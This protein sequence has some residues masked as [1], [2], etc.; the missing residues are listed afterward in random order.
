[1]SISFACPTCG[2]RFDAPDHLEGK[3]ARC[4]TC[5]QV[6]TIARETVPI[7]QPAVETADPLS[8]IGTAAMD[9]MPLGTPLP[10]E[11]R[12][13]AR[14]G[15]HPGIVMAIAAGG[16]TVVGL[17]VLLIVFVFSGGDERAERDIPD[18]RGARR[19]QSVS[20]GSRTR[21]PRLGEETLAA[22]TSG[23]LT[24]LTLQAQRPR[25]DVQAVD[26]GEKPI[27][28]VSFARDLPRAVVV[29]VDDN[30]LPKTHHAT[31]YN[32]ETGQAI[33]RVQLPEYTKIIGL[34]PDATAMA[35]ASDHGKRQP[36]KLALWK[37]HDGSAK[38][39]LKII[40][41][42]N[43]SVEWVHFLPP[44]N[45]FLQTS[46]DYTGVFDM[47]TSEQKYSLEV[48]YQSPTVSPCGRWVAIYHEDDG[49]ENCHLQFYNS[50]SG[51]PVAAFRPQFGE[52][53]DFGSASVSPDGRRFVLLLRSYGHLKYI[54]FCWDLET[55]RLVNKFRLPFLKTSD[56]EHPPIWWCGKDYLLIGNQLCH[57]DSGRYVWQYSPAIGQVSTDRV[58]LKVTDLGRNFLVPVHLPLPADRTKI[59]KK[60][61]AVR[62]LLRRGDTVRVE[63][64]GAQNAPT[65][66]FESELSKA[67][68]K[69]LQ[70]KGYRVAADAK[71]CLRLSV[72]EKTEGEPH[73]FEPFIGKGEPFS[74]PD[75]VLHLAVDLVDAQG[76]ITR[77]RDE[78]YRIHAMGVRQVRGRDPAS[79]ILN[80]RWDSMIW[81]MKRFEFPK[82]FCD[83]A[84]EGGFGSTE[85]TLASFGTLPTVAVDGSPDE[86]AGVSVAPAAP[87]GPAWKY[88]KDM[89]PSPGK[90]FVG[91]R[92]KL[93]NA[94]LFDVRFAGP[95]VGQVAT[96]VD[97]PPKDGE[98]NT[99]RAVQRV[100]LANSEQL[101]SFDVADDAELLD[102]RLDGKVI[103]VKVPSTANQVADR[104][105]IWA[106]SQQG[107]RQFLEWAPYKGRS[108]SELTSASLVGTN[109]L[110]TVDGIS[111]LDLWELPDR[112]ELASTAWNVRCYPPLSS[113]RKY[114]AVPRDKVIEI[115]DT[116]DFSLAGRLPSD[117]VTQ[118][119]FNGGAFDRQGQ[120]FAAVVGSGP[121]ARF[122]VWDLEKG[123]L[124]KQFPTSTGDA[125]HRWIDERYYYAGGHLIDFQE[126]AAVWKY[127]HE[128]CISATPDGRFWYGAVGRENRPYLCVTQVPS[129]EVKS[130]IERAVT[131]GLL[132]GPGLPVSVRTLTEG[133]PPSEACRQ[134]TK[135]VEE[136]LSK[137]G[138]LVQHGAHVTM[139]V[140]VRNEPYERSRSFGFPAVA[141]ATQ[142]RCSVTLTLLDSEGSSYWFAHEVDFVEC[143]P[144]GELREGEEGP[145]KEFAAWVRSQLLSK[146]VFRWSGHYGTAG[147]S[148]LLYDDEE[149][150]SKYSGR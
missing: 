73:R 58:W 63:V 134:L 28:E 98:S 99:T 25:F 39:F 124:I 146:K 52:R 92:L 41:P 100:D 27:R 129:R 141:G 48:R 107:D 61:A 54:G 57:L 135:A 13:R 71:I 102:F 16:A 84:L 44:P 82:A 130:A 75:R 33:G 119:N 114:V 36:E 72:S 32:L 1:M 101:S 14:R 103:A 138:F 53:T 7:V 42:G 96:L 34:A 120:R 132:L 121:E 111:T 95:E 69:Q 35:I 68:T 93:S 4:Q 78:S 149:I 22:T 43:E 17:V 65:R 6:V 113:Q 23:R 9:E 15:M 143:G 59:E 77:H 83:P 3:Q 76:K 51:E 148:K 116:E 144:S 37:W 139:E 64:R 105:E 140:T 19:D 87:M 147:E 150:R 91:K 66:I 26:V 90:E 70:A 8:P 67:A 123:D 20:N 30:A 12:P 50:E 97:L 115:L 31:L 49:P 88:Q 122:I 85:I 117:A 142:R 47:V 118:R 45:L 18:F 10:S 80:D 55:R 136:T 127:D 86:V 2:R 131:A 81:E 133:N 110:L 74:V 108:Y 128:N 29:H 38:H 56:F 60:L 40:P 125:G 11:Y 109:R 126:E 145:W 94:R 62:P 79:K 137:Q 89:A 112:K 106:C 24:S 46:I 5:G 21:L 104:L